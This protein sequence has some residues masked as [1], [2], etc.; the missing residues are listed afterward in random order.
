MPQFPSKA[1][2][3]DRA[4]Q[5]APVKQYTGYDDMICVLARHNKAFAKH[6]RQVCNSYSI[7]ERAICNQCAVAS[8]SVPNIVVPVGH[9]QNVRCVAMSNIERKKREYIQQAWKHKNSYMKYIHAEPL[10]ADNEKH[11]DKINYDRVIQAARMKMQQEILR[12]AQCINDYDQ[13]KIDKKYINRHVKKY[14]QD[15]VASYRTNPNYYKTLFPAVKRNHQI[16]Q[17][18]IASYKL[19]VCSDAYEYPANVL[20]I[21]TLQY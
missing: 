17:L 18:P 7:R 14:T 20:D 9:C 12:S 10:G 11:A 16:N 1:T 4:A 13:L 5:Q 19:G 2:Y 3:D 6:R 15:R 21:L 8:K